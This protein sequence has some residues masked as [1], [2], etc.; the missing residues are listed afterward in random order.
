MEASPEINPNTA[1]KSKLES[2]I[3]EFGDVALQK[4][5]AVDKAQIRKRTR[6]A[7]VCVVFVFIFI[8]LSE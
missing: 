6:E 3:V 1:R 5:W 7:I 4:E 8:P 2:L